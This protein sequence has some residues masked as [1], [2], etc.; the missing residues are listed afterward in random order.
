MSQTVL[1]TPFGK[2]LIDFL[3]NLA[4]SFSD[5]TL[6]R[7]I[8][9]QCK[10]RSDYLEQVQQE[11]AQFVSPHDIG[12]F[13]SIPH[14]FQAMV[15]HVPVSHIFHQLQLVQKYKLLGDDED[16][17]N[18]FC[19]CL[20]DLQHAATSEELPN[21]ANMPD[22][23]QLSLVDVT[24]PVQSIPSIPVNTTVNT[25]RFDDVKLHELCVRTTGDRKFVEDLREISKR[26]PLL[27]QLYGNDSDELIAQKLKSMMPILK[28]LL[29]PLKMLS[30]NKQFVSMAERMLLPII[31]QL[32]PRFQNG[33]DPKK[34]GK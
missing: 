9:H 10:T 5:C 22:L 26:L 16:A 15:D 30:A 8:L 19:E 11:W 12:S 29:G 4:E 21:L 27:A 33:A 31:K 3:E 2:T 25:T 18:D 24:Q 20:F 13:D 23:S 14:Y 28:G 34:Y 6:T 17:K 32:D 7:D 1:P